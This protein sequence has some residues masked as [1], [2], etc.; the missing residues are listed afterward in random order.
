L[1]E[2]TGFSRG[3]WARPLSRGVWR[4]AS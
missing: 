3:H 2:K 4:E 1:V